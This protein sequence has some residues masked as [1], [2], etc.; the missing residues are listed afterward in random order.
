MIVA[1]LWLNLMNKPDDAL[2]TYHK[3]FISSFYLLNTVC[4]MLDLQFA[5]G[6]WEVLMS[7]SPLVAFMVVSATLVHRNRP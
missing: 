2:H 1:L 6:I 5:P 7:T 4:G 3:T